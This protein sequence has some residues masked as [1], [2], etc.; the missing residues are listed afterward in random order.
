MTKMFTPN[1]AVVC[2]CLSVCGRQD[3]SLPQSKRD[4]SYILL[5]SAAPQTHTFLEVHNSGGI[6]EKL[7]K[8]T[9]A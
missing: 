8:E 5:I 7:G 2:E 9:C 6:L 1:V 3:P 4:S